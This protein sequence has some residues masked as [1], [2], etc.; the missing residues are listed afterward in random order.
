MRHDVVRK[1]V[2]CVPSWNSIP[3]WDK[4]W[5]SRSMTSHRSWVIL[6]FICFSPSTRNKRWYHSG[7]E[8][9]ILHCKLPWGSLTWLLF[10][11]ELREVRSNCR[12]HCPLVLGL[13]DLVKGKRSSHFESFWTELPGL[14][15]TINVFDLYAPWVNFHQANMSHSCAAI[16]EAKAS[17]P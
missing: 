8:G 2:R 17:G 15:E 13:K 7:M 14:L 9:W 16:L 5:L 6:W 10:W 12:S 4:I 11:K 1:V 3:T